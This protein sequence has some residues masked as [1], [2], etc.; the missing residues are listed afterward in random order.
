MDLALTRDLLQEYELE[1]GC[2]RGLTFDADVSSEDAA[3]V[4][5]GVAM[6]EEGITITAELGGKYFGGILYGA[7][8]KYNAPVTKKAV[9]TRS[10][11]QAHCR[12]CAE[13]GRDA[14]PRSRQSLRKQPAQHRIASA[15]R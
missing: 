15:W 5:R 13:E 3:T 6:L 2:S 8:A 1:I 9:G 12:F 10:T 14:R 11:P 7:M 4:A